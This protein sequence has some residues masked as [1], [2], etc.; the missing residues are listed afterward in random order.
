MT[1]DQTT[2]APASAKA[3]PGR[4]RKP[5]TRNM[6]VDSLRG[7]ACILLVT[8][9]VV[10]DTAS[11]GIHVPDDS[12][13]RYY[14]DSVEYLGM[15]LFTLLSGLVY[16]WRP[17]TLPSK[18]RD[19]MTKKARRL[20]VPYIIF[21]PLLG[22]TQMVA[23]DVNDT[24][25]FEPLSWLLYSLGPYWFLLTTFWMFAVV[26]LADAYGL[27]RSPWVFGGVFLAFTA[28]V[29]LGYTGGLRAFQFSQA[30]TLFPFFLAGVGIH[31][32]RLLPR[33]VPAALAWTTGLIILIVTVQLSA[34]PWALCFPWPSSAGHWSP[35][36]WPG[37]AAT[38]LGSFCCT[39]SASASSARSPV[40]SGSKPISRSSSS[41]PSV[42][43]S[44]LSSASS[45][46]VI[47]A[48]VRSRSV[49]SCSARKERNE[50]PLR[51]H[52]QHLPL[53]S[54]GTPVA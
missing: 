1:S 52:R 46:S 13:W 23:P 37:S 30:L 40:P 10:G 4:H 34:L 31:R 36:S 48:S 6:P 42:A 51:L 12:A 20:L 16:A 3:P 33:S 19:F 28:V 11:A 17:L 45:F 27:L 22:M 14:T 24:V 39:P 35:G 21:V 43:S 32:F 8:F 25:E 26:A 41:T 38:P 29:I 50:H 54:R 47:S 53:P 49:A 44:A 15:P 5:P 18:Y 2:R 7:L 9:H